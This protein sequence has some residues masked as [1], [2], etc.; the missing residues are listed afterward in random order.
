M[1]RKIIQQKSAYTLTLPIKWVRDHHLEGKAEVE[2]E[3]E[4][5]ALTIRAEKKA[6]LETISLTLEKSTSEYYRIMIE[7]HYLKGFDILNCKILDTK[8]FPIIQKVVSNIIGFE[9]IDH[10]E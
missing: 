3:E 6:T 7:N 9:I 10:K 2:V 5:D 8:A 1:R 4:A